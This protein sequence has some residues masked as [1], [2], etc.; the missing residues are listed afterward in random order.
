MAVMSEGFG[1]VRRSIRAHHPVGWPA[2]DA[3][4]CEEPAH[5]PPESF[6]ELRS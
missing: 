3:S 1:A 6:R 4:R 5:F 2:C